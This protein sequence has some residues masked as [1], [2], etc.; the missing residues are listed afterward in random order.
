[1]F[2]LKCGMRRAPDPC[3]LANYQILSTYEGKTDTWKPP[4]LPLKLQ[5]VRNIENRISLGDALAP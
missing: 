1:M 3:G 5:T 2:V 4:V